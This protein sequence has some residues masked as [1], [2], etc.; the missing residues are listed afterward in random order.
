MSGSAHR[1][2]ESVAKDALPIESSS[3]DDAA[4]GP[5]QG[6][7][8][9]G[10]SRSPATRSSREAFRQ[11]ATGDLWRAALRYA[12][13]RATLVRRAGAR[14]DHLYAQDLVE[15]ALGDTWIGT[16]V[17]WDPSQCSLREHIRTLIRSRSWKDREA[18]EQ[19]PHISVDW[20][21]D[22]AVEMD[23]ST[24]RDM[25]GR[26]SPILFGCVIDAIIAELQRQA[27]GDNDAL[28]I[29]AAWREDLSD[30]DDVIAYTGLS[31]REYRKAR[32][33]L[34]YLVQ[35]LPQPLRDDA[36]TLLKGAP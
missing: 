5:G 19:R 11:Q 18:A 16:Q 15:D 26:D 34:T 17:T 27:S 13:R 25:A 6:P 4:D 12:R 10:A 35:K 23:E 32:A 36:R 24:R 20:D 2:K 1:S 3:D 14:I 29:L 22:D 30:R 7:A 8:T 31:A 9:G 33:R 21:A 28:A